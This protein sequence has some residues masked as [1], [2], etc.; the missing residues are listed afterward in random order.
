[1]LMLKILGAVLTIA[2]SAAIGYYF[3]SNLKDRIDDLKELRKNMVVLRGDIRYAITPLPEAVGAIALRHQGN[4]ARFFGTISEKLMKLEGVSFCEVWK[5]TVTE[6]L[7]KTA[8]TKQD[9]ES[10]SKIGENLGYLDKEMQL[11]ILD[12]YIEQLEIEIESASKVRGEK[13]KLYNTL[14]VMTGVFITIVML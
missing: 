3:S 2:S 4:F 14:G 6:E 11:N 8:L 7:V 5:Q 13:A 12:L 1:M 10:L 9:K